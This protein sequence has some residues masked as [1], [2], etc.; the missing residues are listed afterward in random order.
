VRTFQSEL[1]SVIPPFLYRFFNKIPP[2][3]FAGSIPVNRQQLPVVP[4]KKRSTMKNYNRNAAAVCLIQPPFVQLNSPYPSLY[5]LRSFLERRGHTVTVQDHSI[6]LFETIFCRTGLD[7]IFADV[8][9]SAGKQDF[10][11][12]F[13]IFMLELFLSNEDRWLSTIDRT[14]DFLRGRDHEWGHFIAAANEFL[15]CGPRFNDYLSSVCDSRGRAAPEYAPLLA[16]KLLADIADFITYVADENFSLIRYVPSPSKSSSTGFRDFSAVLRGMN[17]YVMSNFYHPF[18][19]NTWRQL[20]AWQLAAKAPEKLILGLGIPFPG[21][22]AGALVCAQSAKAFFGERVVTVAG[23]GYVNTE[24]RYLEDERLFDYFDYLSFD[25]GYGSLSAIVECETT[26][27]KT[28][29]DAALYKTMYRNSEGSI[30]K[31]NNIINN[32]VNNN[33]GI[34][35]DD[36]AAATVFPDYSGVDFSRYIHPADDENPMHRL[37]SD[38]RWLKAYLAHGCYWHNCAFCDTSLD[39]IRCYKPVDVDA[40]FRH[41]LAQA[42]ATGIRG[43]HLVDEACPPASLLRLA[44][45]NREAGLPLVFW[46]NIRFEKA[47]TPDVAAI[48]AAGG[49]IGVSAGIEVAAEQGLRRIGKGVDL[50]DIVNVCAAFKEAKILVHAYCIYGYWDQDERE[51]ADSAEILRQFFAERLLDSAFWHQ[52]TLTKHSRIYAEKQKGLHPLLK[53]GGDPLCGKTA[54]SKNKIFALNDLSFAGEQKFNRYA[55]PLNRLLGEWMQGDTLWPN[56]DKLLKSAVAP[57]LI[58]TLAIDYIRRQDKIRKSL[59][60]SSSKE[61]SRV[62]FLVSN[63]VVRSLAARLELMW[64]WHLRDYSLPL[65]PEQAKKILSLLKTASGGAGMDAL[66]FYDKLE[67]IFGADAQRV[68]RKLRQRGLMLW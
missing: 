57:D 10:R 12:S 16:N 17:G 59:P 6:G 51:I 56:N 48:L 27:V 40:L 63:A 34:S 42:E 62:I 53:P 8:K 64:Y 30:I 65:K 35:I 68:W 45:L 25:R 15:P 7:R 4:A 20:A 61:T 3:A 29:N 32:D 23:G 33:T 41:L 1:G 11:N 24:L 14:V 66:L 44:L 55:E 37:W 26:H 21:C 2:D 18:L 47:F 5:Y 52:F 38:G 67:T 36:D 19:E 54:K 39:Y 60:S 43:V 9:K 58:G 28:E 13:T 31:D 22:L 50:R 46:G 49:L